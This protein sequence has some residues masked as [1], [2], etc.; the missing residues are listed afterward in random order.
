MG[1]DF[2]QMFAWSQF[3]SAKTQIFKRDDNDAGE[4]ILTIESGTGDGGTVT[5]LRERD[6]GDGF[7][8]FRALVETL[9]EAL[10]QAEANSE[11]H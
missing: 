4:L 8:K 1:F 11:H 7:V 3:T 10:E 9:E 2:S 5:I 6:S